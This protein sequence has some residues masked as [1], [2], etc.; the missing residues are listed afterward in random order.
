MD[1]VTRIQAE[2][3]E[4]HIYSISAVYLIHFQNVLRVSNSWNSRICFENW[5]WFATL[6]LGMIQN[7]SVMCCFTCDR[8]LINYHYNLWS[9]F[10]ITCFAVFLSRGLNLYVL[11][12]DASF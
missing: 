5:S 10:S 9:Q 8:F 6:K 4:Q 12:R 1:K 3:C 2:E 11:Q 7:S